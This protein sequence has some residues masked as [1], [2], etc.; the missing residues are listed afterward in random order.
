[1]TLV[2]DS[3]LSAV[4]AACVDTLAREANTTEQ[5]D[6]RLYCGFGSVGRALL[7]RWRG[8]YRVNRSGEDFRARGRPAFH[9]TGFSTPS[10][11]AA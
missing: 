2:G 1:M 7:G 3:A 6:R 10:P 9:A 11:Q 5:L 8:T 4:T